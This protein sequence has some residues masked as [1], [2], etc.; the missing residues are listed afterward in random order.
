[1]KRISDEEIK[2][3]TSHWNPLPSRLDGIKPELIK[4]KLFQTIAQAQL[5]S[6]EKELKEAMTKKDEKIKILQGKLKVSNEERFAYRQ[7]A[8][9]DSD[10][11]RNF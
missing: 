6:C 9:K 10:F 11:G 5:E 8:I 3:L 4:F 2:K 1:M 7:R